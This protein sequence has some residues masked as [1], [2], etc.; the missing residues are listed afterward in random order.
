M[1]AKDADKKKLELED[2]TVRECRWTVKDA[3]YDI[4]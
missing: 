3:S 4:H 1:A 2:F